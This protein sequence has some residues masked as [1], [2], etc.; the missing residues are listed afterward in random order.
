MKCNEFELL[1]SDYLDGVMLPPRKLDFE[2]HLRGCDKCRAELSETMKL[3]E[4][5]AALPEGIEPPLDLWKN[6][7]TRIAPTNPVKKIHP[8]NEKGDIEKYRAH[9]SN[10]IYKYAVITLIAAV[11]L[12]T[13][14]P[15]LLKNKISIQQIQDKIVP[16]WK[17]T[18]TMGITLLASNILD[19]SGY[20]KEGEELET[21]DSS[22]AVI[23]IDNLGTVTLEP[24]TRIR[25]VK[26]DSVEKR[27][28]V[29][30]GSVHAKINAKPRT[31]FVDTKSVTA[32]DLGCAY[33]LTVDSSGDAMLY[34]DSGSVIL[35]SNGRESLV[36]AGKYCMAKAGIGP[37]TPYR[38]NASK[39]FKDALLSYDFGNGGSEAVNTLLKHAKKTDA[40]T[41][42]NMLPRIEGASKGKVYERLKILA[43]PPVNFTYDSIPHMDMNDLQEWIQKLQKDIHEE[44]KMRMEELQKELKEN[45]PGQI[46]KDLG[47][48]YYT[49]E[50]EEQI[51]ESI[52]NGLKGLN[53]L[54]SLEG[55][56]GLEK[57]KDLQGLDTLSDN[58]YFDSEKFNEQMEKMNEE[59]ER[60]NEQ[61]EK[62]VEKMNERMNKFNEEFQEKMQKKQ[63]EMQQKMQ[64]KQEKMH[65]KQQEF[66]QRELDKELEKQQ[67]LLDKELEKQQEIRDKELEKQQELRDKEQEQ[68]YKEQEQ[69]DKEQSQRDKEQQQ[70]DK[71]Q[72][73]DNDGNN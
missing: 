3:L 42:I 50:L 4:R 24:N 17:V 57:L 48:E 27:I 8:L 38:K 22:R 58:S 11:I 67:E 5:I 55:L 15:S 51:M 53:A 59:L 63:E 36:P 29:L 45:L 69:R 1:I 47:D 6:I 25:F 12:I 21:K 32:I 66:N 18:K 60:N 37:G 10:R 70:Q 71:D 73:N 23:E 28:S 14:L 43:P 20:M 64:E 30:Y 62:N 46:H 41:L 56:K 26:S 40:V 68:R 39:E 7:E 9:K 33:N 44:V 49:P 34:V 61:I 13:F 65:E 2:E 31:F 19:Q 72:N 35:T 52:E 54:K 16:T